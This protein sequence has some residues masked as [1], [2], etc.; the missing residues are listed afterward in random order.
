MAQGSAEVGME[1]AAQLQARATLGRG[2]RADRQTLWPNHP[3]GRIMLALDRK[4]VDNRRYLFGG[5]A[6][7]SHCAHRASTERTTRGPRPFTSSRSTVFC[8][9][10]NWDLQVLADFSGKMVVDLGVAWNG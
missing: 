1:R 9:R 3:S 6:S 5:G 4:L 8:S 10:Q 2:N 7:S